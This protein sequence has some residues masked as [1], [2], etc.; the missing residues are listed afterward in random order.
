MYFYMAES[1]F[2]PALVFIHHCHSVA[3]MPVA[4]VAGLVSPIASICYKLATSED[5]YVD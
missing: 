1:Y 5:P 4:T 2:L 3:D